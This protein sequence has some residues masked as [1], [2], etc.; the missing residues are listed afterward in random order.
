VA[1]GGCL[2]F[3]GNFTGTTPTG[4]AV[5]KCAKANG[6]DAE[7]GFDLVF[8]TRTNGVGDVTERVRIGS[9]GVVTLAGDLDHNGTNVG[10]YGT[11]PIAKQTGVTVDAAGIH[12]ALVALGLI[13]A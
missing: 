5:I 2:V 7:Y 12:A 11:A 8:A 1:L 10:F 4:G 6:V 9:T 13:T 3:A